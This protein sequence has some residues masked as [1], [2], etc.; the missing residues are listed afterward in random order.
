M[1]TPADRRPSN[2]SNERPLVLKA[3]PFLDERV[4]E[5]PHQL[6]D[7][8]VGLF[9]GHLRVAHEPL[10]HITPSLRVPV[11]RSRYEPRDVEVLTWANTVAEL[12]LT[13]QR[14]S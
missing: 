5:P 9:D 4:G 12:R 3:A 13:A 14:P 10:L 8:P 11:R 2:A 7:K 6:G 1:L